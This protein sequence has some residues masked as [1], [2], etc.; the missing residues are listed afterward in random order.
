VSE[1]EPDT[2]E[3]TRADFPAD[4]VGLAPPDVFDPVLE[5]YKKDVDRTLLRENL[6]LSPAERAEKFLSFARFTAELAEA[7]RRARAKDPEWG[8]RP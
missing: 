1:R 3:P 7:G 5:V 2:A 6:K 4:L 8:S